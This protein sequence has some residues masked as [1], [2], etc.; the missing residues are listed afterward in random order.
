MARGLV[1]QHQAPSLVKVLAT[2][3]F[4]C[5]SFCCM[6]FGFCTHEIKVSSTMEKQQIRIMRKNINCLWL[7]ST[8]LPNEYK[9]LLWDTTLGYKKGN[10]PEGTVPIYVSNYAERP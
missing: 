7:K 2:F 3:T 6:G 10:I 4:A 9:A 1:N 5:I 8:K